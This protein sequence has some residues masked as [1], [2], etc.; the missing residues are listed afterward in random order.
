MLITFF[1]LYLYQSVVFPFKTEQIHGSVA[2]V[3]VQATYISYTR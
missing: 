2:T 1:H 3:L